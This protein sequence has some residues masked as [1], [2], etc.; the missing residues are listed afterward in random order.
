[1]HCDLLMGSAISGGCVLVL[2][3]SSCATLHNLKV[4]VV[5]RPFFRERVSSLLYDRVLTTAKGEGR[6]ASPSI[7]VFRPYFR[8]LIL[9]KQ[10]GP[11]QVK[12]EAQK[13]V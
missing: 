12:V 3:V 5:L 4:K 9:K 2:L 1:M 8:K 13:H 6:P 11:T 10:I 7:Q